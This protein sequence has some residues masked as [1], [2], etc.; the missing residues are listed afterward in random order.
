MN[1]IP[2]ITLLVDNDYRFDLD[3]RTAAKRAHGVLLRRH[4]GARSDAVEVIGA[5]EQAGDGRWQA[6]ML[7]AVGAANPVQ[8]VLGRY[9]M[10]VDAIVALWRGRRTTS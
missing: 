5:V 8:L 4:R 9:A 3:G 6:Y 7:P 10:R 2:N 1:Y